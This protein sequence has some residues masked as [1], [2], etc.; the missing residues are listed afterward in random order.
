[1]KWNQGPILIVDDD[2]NDV[3]LIQRGLQR[4]GVDLPTWVA[5][6]VPAARAYLAGHG[7][8]GQRALHPLPGLIL[9]DLKLP[10]ESGIDLL[11]WIR[12]VD[13]LRRIPVVLLSSS[14]EAVDVDAAY[15]AGCNS[16]LVKP[17]AFDAL[18]TMLTVFGRYWFNFNTP[19]SLHSGDEVRLSGT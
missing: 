4:A 18:Q 10:G 6:N 3:V 15:D 11:R 19:P 5:P 13:G 8:F 17:V 14:R 16:Y 1:L 7:R 2:P 9:L 12:A